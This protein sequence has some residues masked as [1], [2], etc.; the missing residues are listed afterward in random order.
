MFHWR[1][2]DEEAM[3]VMHVVVVGCGSC[4]IIQFGL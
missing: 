3:V 1:L 4:W 2:Q